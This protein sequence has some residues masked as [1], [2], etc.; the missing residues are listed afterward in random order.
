MEEVVA[1]EGHHHPDANHQFI[2]W[3]GGG[4]EGGGRGVRE[5]M[6]ENG[7]RMGEM[8]RDVVG[9]R[10]GRGREERRG[11]GWVGDEVG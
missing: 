10:G 3:R 4:G 6:I 8:V 7:E 5:G 1:K 11:M 9:E 2:P